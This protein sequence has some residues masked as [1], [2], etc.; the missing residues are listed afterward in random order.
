MNKANAFFAIFK[1][2][3]L[4]FKNTKIRRL[5]FIPWIV[6][7]VS[8]I[9]TTWVA[10]S[11]RSSLL[12][13]FMSEGNSFFHVFLYN[14][15]SIGITLLLLF[16]SMLISIIL[17]LILT[18][19]FQ[20]AIASEVLRMYNHE[21]PQQSNGIKALL[22]ETLRT[23]LTESFKLIWLL[24]LLLLLFF[25][26]LIPIFTPIALVCSAWLLA[27]QFIDIVLDVLLVK[28]R[29]RLFFS[30]RNSL[31]LICFGFSLT[32]LWAIPFLGLFLVPAATAGAS[33][34]LAEDGIVKAF[35]NE[36]G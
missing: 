35:E 29:N 11:Y 24:P 20:S 3:S 16:A 32:I 5:A 10:L 1:G 30:L 15:A 17:V 21:C 23:M 36:K 18:S 27:Y 12:A 13:S 22:S 26:G 2:T 25:L 33:W 31:T 7:S 19:V 8:Y 4:C 28:A 9:L 34:L 14:L 6:A